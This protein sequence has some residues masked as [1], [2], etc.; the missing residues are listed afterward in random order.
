M[1][2]NSTPK[3]IEYATGATWP[4]ADQA[5]VLR[6]IMQ[7]RRADEPAVPQDSESELVVG[8]PESAE[9]ESDQTE[10]LPEGSRKAIVIAVTG[11]KGGVGKSNVSL[12]L[13]IALTQAERNVVLID[14]NEGHGNAD[15]LCGLNGYWNLEHV[16]N[17]TRSVEQVL[18]EGPGGLKILPGAEQ[19]VALG[20]LELSDSVANQLQ[21]LESDYD[22]IVIDAGIA[23]NQ[24]IRATIGAADCVLLVTSPEP[25][26]IADTYATIKHLST[27]TTDIRVAV[28]MASSFEQG[29]SVFQRIQQTAQTFLE[30]DVEFIGAIPR[31]QTVVDAVHDRQPFVADTPDCP[32]SR[33]IFQIAERL[34][35]S[36]TVQHEDL[37]MDRITENHSQRAAA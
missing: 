13:A 32:A 21:D 23:A 34:L 24:A 8:E 2:Q 7:Q 11:G 6:Q 16:L 12:N 33:C 35:E 19:L 37:F 22:F 20:K 5:S 3:D 25:T 1:S 15:L 29:W 9:P 27:T 18:L 31:D 10:S 36:S 30:R 26:S 14:A 17:Q 28:N 4:V